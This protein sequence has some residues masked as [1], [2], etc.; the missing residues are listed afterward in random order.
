M[1]Q[2]GQFIR[3]F[4]PVI[5]L[6]EFLKDCNP[7]LQPHVLR[8]VQLVLEHISAAVIG[9][10][11]REILIIFHCL[12]D[13]PHLDWQVT[14]GINDHSPCRMA[15]IRHFQQQ[16]G[17][18]KSSVHLIQITDGTKHHHAFYPCPVN[19]IRYLCR[20][21]IFLLGNQCFDFLCPYFVLIFI[22]GA[23]STVILIRHNYPLFYHISLP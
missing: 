14:Q 12:Y 10:Y 11:L 16:L 20:I 21:H 1:V 22:Q 19:C 2:I 5:P 9:S 8:F 23:T 7:L 13:F 17:I 6:F 4:F 18:L 3:P 15:L